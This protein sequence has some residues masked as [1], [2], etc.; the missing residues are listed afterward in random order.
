MTPDFTALPDRAF[1][2]VDAENW[3]AIKRD[4]LYSATALFERAG[5]SGASAQPFAGWR[6]TGRGSC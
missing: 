4:G 6:A 3:P 2:L 5:L 1:H